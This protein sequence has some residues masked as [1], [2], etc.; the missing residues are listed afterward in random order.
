M[1][2]NI[3]KSDSSAT[4]CK[5]PPATNFEA[6]ITPCI[7][8][9]GFGYVIYNP[10]PSFNIN[11][12]A[13]IYLQFRTFMPQGVLMMVSSFASQ[14]YYGVFVQN[15]RIVFSI[16]SQNVVVSLTSDLTYVNGQWYQV[17]A[18]CE[19]KILKS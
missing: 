14:D 17:D 12:E 9:Y 18:F 3:L 11:P 2:Q 5:K 15:E 1:W 4:C 10:S 16:F 7:T 8:F 6:L 19:I 13:Q